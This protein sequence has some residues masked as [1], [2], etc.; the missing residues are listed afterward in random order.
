MVESVATEVW[1]R[2][3]DYCIRECLELN[4]GNIVWDEGY[5][6]SRGINPDKF[7]QLYYPP[8]MPWRMLIIGSSDEGAKLIT[9]QTSSAR[10]EALFP[11]WE[12]GEPMAL[13]EEM[14]DSEDTGTVVINRSPSAGT[15]VGR[16]FFRLLSEMQEE[17]PQT[18]I[19]VHGMY[20]WRVM[21]GLGFKSV[22]IDPRTGAKKGKVMLP[23]GKEVTYEYA[24]KWPQ[25]ITIFGYK[26]IDLAVP[27][28]RCMYNI[29]SALW[30][31]EH[32]R[33]D[34]KFK[35][36]GKVVVD[37]DA[38]HEELATNNSIFV[39]RKLQPREGDYFLCELC[40]LQTACKYFR[41]GSVC[42]VPDS[43]PA[44]LARFFKTRNSD[45]IIEG[46]GT[47]LAA[48]SARL[49]RAMADE[50]MDGKTSPEVTKIINT[51]FDRGV[52]LAKLVNP[53]L[54]AAG[55][56][57]V[58]LV[59]QNNAIQAGTPQQLMAAVVAELEGRGIPRQN[60]TPEMIETFLSDPEGVKA[61]AIEVAT[62]DGA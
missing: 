7:M 24:G 41:T 50:L 29:K 61:R 52:K 19:H 38:S 42:S 40:S 23:P 53:T 45:T 27:R 9:P 6:N 49:E 2:N 3:P 32:Y 15:G 58:N 11:V 30:A 55:A 39:K 12:Y 54:A 21:F 4:F 14:L 34:V 28:V 59:Q 60:I 56:T 8:T 1:V 36:N 48:E 62:A 35:P 13:L 46:L 37:P 16:S 17:N 43:E 5:L 25:W 51:L 10:P 44:E 26:P 18:N 33:T 22:D 57:R 47:L 20:S 31:A